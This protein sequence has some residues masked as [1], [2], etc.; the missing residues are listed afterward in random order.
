MSVN[1]VTKEDLEDFK[2]ELLQNMQDLLKGDAGPQKKWLK[3]SE[4]RKLLKISPGTLQNLRVNGHLP[5]TRVG[6]TLFYAY[7][8]IIEMLE[9]N[10]RR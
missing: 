7:Q 6:G 3:S 4:V 8:D 2:R 5:Y 1:I 9:E 10:K